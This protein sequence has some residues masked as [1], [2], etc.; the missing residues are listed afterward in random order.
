MSDSFDRPEI[1]A[2]GIM[3]GLDEEDRRLLGGYGEFLPVHPDQQL[4][5]EGKDQDSLYFVISGVLH[6][7]T[8][9]KEKRTLVARVGSGETLGEVNLFD[10]A[11]ASASVTAKEFSQVWKA[12]R[13]DYEDFKA[14]YP[15]AA[16]QLL[17]GILSEMSQR[18]R[19]MNEK[20]ATREAEAAF[21]S[22]WS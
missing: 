7:H 16:A 6:V 15:A 11:T 13:S 1:P 21:Q 12:N 9:T 3:S 14:S 22:F 20:L 2:S 5:E 17:E 19:R 8:D 10:P 4:I 18:L